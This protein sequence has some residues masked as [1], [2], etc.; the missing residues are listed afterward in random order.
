VGG[1]PGDVTKREIERAFEVYGPL[2]EVVI[3]N[4]EIDTFAFV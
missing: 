2:D 4:S 3:R 1:L